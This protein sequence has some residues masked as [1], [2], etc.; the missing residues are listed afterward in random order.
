MEKA[1]EIERADALNFLRENT[2]AVIATSFND[3]PS[4]STVYSFVDDEF[5]FYFIT[6]RNTSKYI[7]LQMNPQAAVVVGTGPR[8]ISVQA[9]GVA[10]LIADEAERDRILAILTGIRER[11]KDPSMLWPIEQLSNFKDRNKVAFM[12]APTLLMY[13]NMDDAKHSG[14]M[15]NEFMQII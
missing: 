5:N 4:A 1:S 11:A 14:T 2:T 15:G 9:K 8:H 6:T 13:M 7:N 10:H 12:I 3:E